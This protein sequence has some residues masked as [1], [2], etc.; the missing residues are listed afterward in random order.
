MNLSARSVFFCKT[1]GVVDVS[2][3]NNSQSYVNNDNISNGNGDDSKTG[4]DTKKDNYHD[5]FANNDI[6]SDI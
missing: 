3:R 4:D 1:Y 5:S 2:N 6:G